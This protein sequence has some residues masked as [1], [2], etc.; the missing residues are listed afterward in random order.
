MLDPWSTTE[1]EELEWLATQPPFN[2]LLRR[3]MKPDSES[4][5]SREP[6]AVVQMMLLPRSACSSDD[7]NDHYDKRFA[8]M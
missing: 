5:A 1:P 8:Y 3:F 6:E 2:Q 7:S 4:M